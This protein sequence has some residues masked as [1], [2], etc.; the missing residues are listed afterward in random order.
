MEA[1]KNYATTAGTESGNNLEE[2]LGIALRDHIPNI[3]VLGGNKHPKP[4]DRDNNKNQERDRNTEAK[5]FR[6]N[7]KLCE[8]ERLAIFLQA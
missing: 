1:I 3:D 2:C 8:M 5:D 7:L 4:Q 6:V